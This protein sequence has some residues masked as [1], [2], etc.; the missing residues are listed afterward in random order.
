MNR[1]ELFEYLEELNYEVLSDDYGYLKILIEYGEDTV[2]ALDSKLAKALKEDD[3]IN[4][5][6]DA[7]ERAVRKGY[8]PSHIEEA[9]E[10][11]MR[12]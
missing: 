4:A 7:V 8:A 9:Y 12:S 1:S 6:L 10:E 5:V 2:E 11:Y 3:A